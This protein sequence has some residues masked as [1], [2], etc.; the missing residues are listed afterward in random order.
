MFDVGVQAG[1]RLPAVALPDGLRLRDLSQRDLRVEVVKPDAVLCSPEQMLENQMRSTTCERSVR[2]GNKV[3]K[4]R[5]GDALVSA[6]PHAREVRPGA[7]IDYSATCAPARAGRCAQLYTNRD[8]S[9]NRCE[10]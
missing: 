10:S 6:A 8:A 2:L 5:C 9:K 3:A 4:L 1:R 7:F